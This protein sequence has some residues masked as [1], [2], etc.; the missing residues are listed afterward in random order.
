MA[1][2][3]RRRARGLARRFGLA[4]KGGVVAACVALALALALVGAGVACSSGGV[5]IERDAGSSAGEAAA[6][7]PADAD[8]GEDGDATDADGGVTD[9]ADADADA[10]ASVQ[11][12]VIVDVDGA[13]AAPGVYA[14]TRTD[15]VR[16]CDVIE[17]AGGLADGADTSSL[18]LAAPI[19][20]GSKVYVPLEGEDAPAQVTGAGTASGTEGATGTAGAS[21]TT[22]VNINTATAEEL[23]T[24]P[25]VGEAT[26]QAI[27]EDREA[28]G[29]FSSK[30]DIM[31]VSGIGEAKYAQMEDLICV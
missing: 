25:G 27:I 23:D 17:A 12:T 4:E 18:N 24:L 1:Q 15:V 29:P 13:V 28:N 21:G 6:A 11:V 8:A 31:R 9:A 26:A 10:T 16:V 2:M 22:L 7:E 5:T 3:E 30:E 14:V 20:D 19:E